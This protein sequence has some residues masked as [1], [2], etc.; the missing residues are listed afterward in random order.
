MGP[1]A[2]NSDGNCAVPAE[3]AEVDT[4]GASNVIGDGTPAGCTS[5]AVVE[6]VARGG[7]IT[8][9]CGPEPVT[10]GLEDTA[11][12]VNDTGPEIVIDGGGRVTLSGQHQRRILY[13]NTCDQ[14]QKFTTPNCDN[15]DHPRLT[16]QNLTFVAG[17]STGETFDGGGG[18]AVFV[19]GG[20]VKIINSR[21]FN[22]RCE[23]VGQDV[24][25]AAVRVLAQ[26]DGQPVYVVNS[27]FGGAADLVNAC[28][29]GGGLSSIGV[30]WTV[31]NS[32]FSH[33][34]ATGNGANPAQ[35][36]TPGGGSGGAIYNDGNQM[37]L[38]VCGTLI[39]NN[40]VNA[41]GG[42]IFFV[43]NNRMGNVVIESSVFR[44]NP[45]GTWYAHQPGISTH[46]ETSVV[47]TDSTITE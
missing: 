46:V 29:N 47:V 22:N 30:S 40:T 12:I 4:R 16:L 39:E 33:N 24:G 45:G 19:R 25:G 17:N 3:A 41:H 13:M 2:G 1:A 34:Q 23:E 37:T 44:N 18:G 28:S 7:V 11:K 35:P 32:V 27:T 31:L 8:F 6:A 43:S 38:R 26:H 9:D 20:R 21:F 36:G 14:A 10:I 15:Q 42:S 5:A